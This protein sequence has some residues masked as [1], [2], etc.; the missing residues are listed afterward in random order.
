MMRML[1][2]LRMYSPLELHPVRVYDGQ[3]SRSQHHKLE[4]SDIM[5]EYLILRTRKARNSDMVERLIPLTK[6]LKEVIAQIPKNGRYV[7]TNSKTGTKYDYRKGMLK[8]LCKRAKVKFFTFHALRH[9][10]ASQLAKEGLP[11]TDI[12]TFLDTNGRAPRIIIC[13]HADSK[14]RWTLS[15]NLNFLHKIP[16]HNI[17]SYK[18]VL[19]L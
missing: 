2:I 8:G 6:P 12:Q 17:P 15:A 16:P 10:G 1:R 11:L 3:G 9:Y 14:V 7:F 5:D 18:K 19:R 4:W 13:S